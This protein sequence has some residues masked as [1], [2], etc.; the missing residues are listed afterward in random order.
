MLSPV[1]YDSLKRMP[2]ATSQTIIKRL[3][4]VFLF[5]ELTAA[6]IFYFAH[7]D[8]NKITSNENAKSNLMS[9]F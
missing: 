1:L 3:L 4:W 7:H 2:T 8:K 5:I 9:F 6:D